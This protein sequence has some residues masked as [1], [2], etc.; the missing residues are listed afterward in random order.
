M[1]FDVRNQLVYN[2]TFKAMCRSEPHSCFPS[3]LTARKESNSAKEKHNDEWRPHE[4]FHVALRLVLPSMRLW[5]CSSRAND[6]PSASLLNLIQAML[7][8]N[9]NFF[10][11]KTGKKNH[12]I[13]RLGSPWQPS[14]NDQ[15][16]KRNRKGK[17]MEFILFSLY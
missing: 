5:R 12:P 16:I 13:F 17:L 8:K 11:E 3:E 2:L 6:T 1:Y 15:R 7:C 9:C 4:F 10:L 14:N